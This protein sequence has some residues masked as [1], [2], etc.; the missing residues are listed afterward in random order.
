MIF[1]L[2]FVFQYVFRNPFLGKYVVQKFQGC[3]FDWDPELQQGLI[4][5]PQQP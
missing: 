5:Q 3:E 1:V 2:G 4:P